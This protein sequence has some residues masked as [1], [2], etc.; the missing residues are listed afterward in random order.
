MSGQVVAGRF[1]AGKRGIHLVDHPGAELSLADTMHVAGYVERSG[2]I[3]ALDHLVFGLFQ[4]EGPEG[5]VAAE[6]GGVITAAGQSDD[7]GDDGTGR[8]E[9]AD[10]HECPS[11]VMS[12][13]LACRLSSYARS[14]S[15]YPCVEYELPDLE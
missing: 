15:W 2:P 10:I 8:D 11:F 12:D 6:L 13:R 14:G 7:S 5:V 4:Q 9:G 1:L 3:D